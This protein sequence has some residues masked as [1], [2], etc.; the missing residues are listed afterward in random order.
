EKAEA[1]GFGCKNRSWT[2]EKIGI[3]V[4]LLFL[5]NRRDQ[6]RI[7][8]H[9]RHHFDAEFPKRQWQG[10]S[11]IGQTSR[12]GERRDLG[13]DGQDF[14]SHPS[15]SIMACVTR[16]TPFSERRKRLASSLGS[17]PTTNPSGMCTPRSMTTFVSR[18]F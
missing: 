6:G 11:N 8:G 12:L 2:S 13:T 5:R 7:A 4:N 16:Q 17:S 1:R 3:A 9:Q 15:L 18:T 10:A 14:H